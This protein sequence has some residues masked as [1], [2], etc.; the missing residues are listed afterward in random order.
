MDDANGTGGRLPR[1]WFLA[2]GAAAVVAGGAGVG[3]GFLQPESKP[4]LK[5]A[6]HALADALAAER[7]LLAWAAAAIRRDPSLQAAAAELTSNHAAHLRALQ[8]ALSPYDTARPT[9]TPTPTF[10]AT[11][12]ARTQ[13]RALERAAAASAATRAGL[14]TG[15][16]AT[17]LASISAC[18]STHAELL[19]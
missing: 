14:L 17:L 15:P 7:E 8:A 11:S 2:G 16:T 6:P 5:P 1:R 4:P 9:P 12:S 19:T 3:I 10:T 18:E 13:L